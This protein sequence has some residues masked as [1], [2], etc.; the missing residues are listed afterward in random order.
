MALTL[1]TYRTNIGWTL[2]RLADEAG[3]TR[4][5]VKNAETG[6][7]IKPETAKAIADTLTKVLGREILVSDIEGLNIM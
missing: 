1:K 4:A 7:L 3:I 5:A 6:H 2:K